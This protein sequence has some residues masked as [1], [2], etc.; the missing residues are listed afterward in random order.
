VSH[1]VTDAMTAHL[2]RMERRS[3]LLEDIQHSIEAL[4]AVVYARTEEPPTG[5]LQ[6][7]LTYDEVYANKGDG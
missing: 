1:Y 5:H 2:A 7:M 4:E 6:P 3:K